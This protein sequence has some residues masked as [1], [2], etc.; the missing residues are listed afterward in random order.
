[1]NMSIID[2]KLLIDLEWYE[3][4]WAFTLNKT[5]EIPLEHIERITAEE[6]HSSWA[7][8]RAPGIFIPGII[9][10]GTY[11]TSKGKEFWYVTRD[12][13]YLTLELKDE[14]YRRIILTMDRNQE[15]IER[16]NQSKSA[17]EERNI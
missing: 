5:I 9:K 14:P 2:N 17:S 6:P 1:M 12:K 4:L 11:Y 15:W 8:I 16:I 3:Q 10:A 7:E 13:D